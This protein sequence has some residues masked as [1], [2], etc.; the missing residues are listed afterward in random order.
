VFP[1]AASDSLVK[2]S[3]SDEGAAVPA[4]M[5]ARRVVPRL[6]GPGQACPVMSLGGP[7]KLE[8]L[9]PKPVRSLYLVVYTDS[10]TG[11]PCHEGSLECQAD[12]REVQ[13]RP[14]SWRRV[15]SV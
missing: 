7:L 2:R 14:P 11:T 3:E 1:D 12:M 10:Q 15:R 5:R 6:P 8:G 9:D 4:W 13:G